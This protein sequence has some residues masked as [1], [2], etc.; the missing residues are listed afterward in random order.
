MS[1]KTDLYASTSWYTPPPDLVIPGAF[2][3][4]GVYLIQSKKI[5]LPRC[6]LLRVRLECLQGIH[7]GPWRRPRLLNAHLEEQ[8]S[9]CSPWRRLIP[10]LVSLLFLVRPYVLACVFHDPQAG[11]LTSFAGYTAMVGLGFSGLASGV[12]DVG[13]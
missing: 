4:C 8:C 13:K 11:Q 2:F 5:V 6:G 12:T 3:S 10:P 9:P 7:D 1:E